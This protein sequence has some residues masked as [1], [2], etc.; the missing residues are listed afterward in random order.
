MRTAPHDL[1]IASTR[2]PSAFVH[3]IILHPVTVFLVISAVFGSITILMTPPLRGPDE[4]PHF[5]RAY[6]VSIFNVNIYDAAKIH[7]EN[8]RIILP[9]FVEGAER[10]AR[11]LREFATVS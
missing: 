8:E 4:L 1:F 3:W 10:M 5:L 7:H 2:P 9:Y 11:I 6:G